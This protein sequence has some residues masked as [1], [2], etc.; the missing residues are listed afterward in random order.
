MFCGAVRSSCVHKSKVKAADV[1][2][3]MAIRLTYVIREFGLTALPAGISSTKTRRL[4][5]QG[6][7]LRCSKQSLRVTVLTQTSS[8]SRIYLFDNKKVSLKRYL[9]VPRI[10]HI[11]IVKKKII[12][13]RRNKLI[14]REEINYLYNRAYIIHMN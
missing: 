4:H 8:E 13:R 9:E 14:L 7:P 12:I 11:Y 2:V 6:T 10:N 1:A 3:N 5:V